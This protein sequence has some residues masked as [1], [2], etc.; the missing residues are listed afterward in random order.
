MRIGLDTALE[1]EAHDL[2]LSIPGGIPQSHLASRHV[3]SSDELLHDVEPSDSC[4]ADDADMGATLGE[5]LRGL[6]T[7][8]SETRIHRVSVVARQIGMLDL[9]TGCARR[10]ARRYEAQRR[11]PAAVHIRLRFDVRTRREQ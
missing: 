11:A 7:S 9:R 10:T 1:Q 4:R 2:S 6:R 3:G 8:V 5:V